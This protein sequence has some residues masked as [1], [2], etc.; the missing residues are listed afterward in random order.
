M[1]S[2]QD[3]V[4]VSIL[5]REYFVGCPEEQRAELAAAAS[6]LDKQMRQIQRGGKVIGPDRCAIMAGL[7]IAHDFLKL[8]EQL[9]ASGEVQNRLKSIRE[10]IDSVMQ[11]DKQLSL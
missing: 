2:T 5:D 7:N 4:K 8:R 1:K 11:Q 3:G 9:T 10:K 6:Y